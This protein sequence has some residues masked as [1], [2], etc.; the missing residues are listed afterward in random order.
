MR[1]K[2][3]IVNGDPKEQFRPGVTWWLLS[4]LFV[5]LL[6]SQNVQ[7]A[8]SQTAFTS[9]K[10]LLTQ[11]VGWQQPQQIAKLASAQQAF[12]DEEYHLSHRLL[13]PLAIQG[14]VLA[15]Y[16]L[17]ML[18]D[19]GRESEGALANAVYWYQ[20]AARNGHHNAQ[21]NLAVAYANGEG[22]AQNMN[23]AVTWWRRAAIAGHTDAQYNL[24]I[25]YATGKNGVERNLSKAAKWWRQAAIAGDP[26]AQYNLAALYANGVETIKSYCEATRWWEKSAASGFTQANLALQVIKLKQDYYSCWE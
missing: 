4:L 12:S 22:V 6:L 25:I 10:I 8:I 1:V 17:A 9:E 18:Y 21:H 7:A 20:K 23:K 11:Q 5:K 14:H 15:Q 3:I 19:S 2:S 16:Q 26:M 13:E 24:G